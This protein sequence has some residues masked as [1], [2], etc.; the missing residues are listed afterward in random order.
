MARVDEYR[1]HV[2]KL[3]EQYS[4]FKKHDSDVETQL[5]FDA[6]RDHYQLVNAGWRNEEHRVYGCVIHIDI[7]NDKIWIQYDGTDFNVANE[8]VAMGVPKKDIVLAFHPP[9]KRPHTE[10]GV[11]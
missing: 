11:N 3:L 4:N 10:F 9:Y 6:E 2:Q 8:L 5:I 7:K 1:T